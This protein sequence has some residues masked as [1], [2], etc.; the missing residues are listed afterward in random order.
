MYRTTEL[1]WNIK[2][3]HET[4]V[5]E[6]GFWPFGRLP[7]N[8]CVTRCCLSRPRNYFWNFKV[9]GLI[10]HTSAVATK[11]WQQNDGMNITIYVGSFLRPICRIFPFLCNQLGSGRL[12]WLVLSYLWTHEN[13]SQKCSNYRCQAVTAL[14]THTPYL[15]SVY[16][17]FNLLQ[18]TGRPTWFKKKSFELVVCRAHFSTHVTVVAMHRPKRITR[19]PIYQDPRDLWKVRTNLSVQSGY[20]STST[21]HFT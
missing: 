2:R 5:S 9:M 7:Y 1:W 10:G 20:R 4:Q 16:T 18:E 21:L 3:K 13:L 8:D 19:I 14:P 6:S 17:H 12:S 11:Q 15:H